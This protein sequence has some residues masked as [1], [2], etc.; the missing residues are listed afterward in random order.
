MVK[1]GTINISPTKSGREGGFTN[2]SPAAESMSNR[3]I[4]IS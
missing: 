4:D 3:E 2:P 1:L